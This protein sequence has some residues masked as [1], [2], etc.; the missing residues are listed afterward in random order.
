[1]IADWGDADKGFAQAARRG[2]DLPLPLSRP[3]A[4]R[5]QLRDRRC[6]ARR[7]SGNVLDPGCLQRACDAGGG[8]RAG[9][10]QSSRA[11]PRKLRHL[12][13]QLL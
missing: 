3:F 6:R 12:R 1:V 10:R 8:A 11:V 7:G 13:A 5:A 2:L 9:G 4:V